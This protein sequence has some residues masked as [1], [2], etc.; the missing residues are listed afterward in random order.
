V[1]WLILT[2]DFQFTAKKLLLCTRGKNVMKFH[3]TFMLSLTLPLEVCCKVGITNF[4][5]FIFLKDLKNSL[6]LHFNLNSQKY[7][8]PVLKESAKFNFVHFVHIFHII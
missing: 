5:L 1:L 4:Y 2:R 8:F 3:L 6:T 7:F